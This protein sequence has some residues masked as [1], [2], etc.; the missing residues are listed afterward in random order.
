M[1][2]KK[3]NTIKLNLQQGKS[4]IDISHLRDIEFR[5]ISS[6]YKSKE[7]FKKITSQIKADDFTFAVNKKIYE[8]LVFYAKEDNFFADDSKKIQIALN[9]YDIFNIH[10]KSTLKILDNHTKHIEDIHDF[11]D[12]DKKEDL[13]LDIFEL[14]DFSK[15]RQEIISENN[16]DNDEKRYSNVQIE[17]EYGLYN[18]IYSNGIILEIGSTYIFHT[19]EELTDVYKYTFENI[20]NYVQVDNYEVIMKVNEDDPKDIHTFCLKK[21]IDK[22]EQIEKLIQWANKY[23]IDHIKLPRVR[24]YITEYSI[25]EDFDKSNLKEIPKEFFEIKKNSF[26]LN[27]INNKI[28]SLPREIGISKCNSLMLCNN[29]FED[30]PKSVYELKKLSTLCLHGNKLKSLPNDID[31]L[32]KLTK[33]SISNNLIKELPKSIS[34]ITTLRELDIENTLIDEKSLEY[35]D[36]RN[37][38]QISFDDKLLPWFIKN[39]HML[40]KIDIIDLVH[41]NY[42]E[43]DDE[44]KA[45]GLE[46]DT[47]SWM[48][49]KDYLGNGCIILF[50]KDD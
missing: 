37:L 8:Y 6:I 27:F 15:K 10:P 14:L 34:N 12:I 40:K 19:P 25:I 46:I 22:I 17:D 29:E 50:K 26:S 31:N 9:I 36:L 49:E 16:N 28:K 47:T 11:I 32:N 43:F 30:F 48:D 7:L 23:K 2:E 45:L 38:E 3:E 39:S 5:I 24:G 33:L 20:I 42:S 13:D 18:G 35:L 4:Y 21:D 41:S 1:K 44:I